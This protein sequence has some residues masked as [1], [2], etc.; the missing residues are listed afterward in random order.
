MHHRYK[1]LHGHYVTDCTPKLQL[2]LESKTC[3]HSLKLYKTSVCSSAKSRSFANRVV[4]PWNSL[5]DPV[6][7]APTLNSFKN[8]LDRHWADLSILYNYKAEV[9]Y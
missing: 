6:V 9:E 5:P 3:G 8:R 4:N 1:I 2:K 7:T